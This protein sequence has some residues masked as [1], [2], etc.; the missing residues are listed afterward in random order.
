MFE[1]LNLDR[2]RLSALGVGGGA[3][4]PAQTNT[5][6]ALT[7][8]ADYGEIATNWRLVFI[9]TYWGSE[10]NNKSIQRF[11]DTLNAALR[12]QGGTDTLRVGRITISDVALGAD[13][14]FSPRR[15]GRLTPYTSAGVTAHVIN[16]EGRLIGG[17][18]VERALDNIT[19]GVAGAVG[20]DLRLPANI[21]VG[22]QLRYDLLSGA[23]FASAR[24]LATYHFGPIRPPAKPSAGPPQ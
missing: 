1:R 2:L 21:S 22:I 20:S 3:V 10:I 6:T 11:E 18:L 14:R 23:R 24:A 9:A 15:F 16:A 13:L 12:D 5:T 17:T 7:L 8:H 19:A 4:R